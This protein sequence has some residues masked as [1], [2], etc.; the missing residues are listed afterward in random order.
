MSGHE[1]GRAQPPR[2]RVCFLETVGPFGPGASL[3]WAGLGGQL[4]CSQALGCAWEGPWKEV[5]P[6]LPAAGLD[7]KGS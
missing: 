6:G 2:L 4:A 1:D 3:G 7:S 5:S